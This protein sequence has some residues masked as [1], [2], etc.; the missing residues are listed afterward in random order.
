M[1]K[2]NS[3]IKEENQDIEI[4]KEELNIPKSIKFN[5]EEE[6]R[7][8][9]RYRAKNI[10]GKDYIPRMVPIT[11]DLKTWRVLI[12]QDILPGIKK[13]DLIPCFEIR[14]GVAFT[15]LD[16]QIVKKDLSFEFRGSIDSILHQLEK[17]TGIKEG[18]E[19]SIPER[20]IAKA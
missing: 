11:D 3:L 7:V 17:I 5:L 12:T 8:R 20:G 9:F 16:C 19:I 1:E 10:L 14:N 18:L 4:I 15:K 13:Q 6:D 2:N